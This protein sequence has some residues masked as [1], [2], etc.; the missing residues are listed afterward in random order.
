MQNFKVKIIPFKGANRGGIKHNQIHQS[1]LCRQAMLD[2]MD[3][4]LLYYDAIPQYHHKK[5][6]PGT[7]SDPAQTQAWH[8]KQ[9]K[10]N[11]SGRRQNVSH[12]IYEADVLRHNN[13]V[14]DIV[15]QLDASGKPD[16]YLTKVI[17]NYWIDMTEDTKYNSAEQF[18]KLVKFN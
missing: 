14:E 1:E 9:L 15:K 3:E 11:M 6:L 13:L 17:D 12:R 10:K 8:I 16:A 2:L 18:L 4:F 7:G 5:K